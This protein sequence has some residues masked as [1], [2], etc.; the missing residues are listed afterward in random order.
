PQA[1]GACRIGRWLYDPA[2]HTLADGDSVLALTGGESN[3]LRAL[4]SRA[5]QVVAR[6]ELAVLC[7]L[8]AGGER[9]IDVQVTR[10][11]RKLE[12]DAKAPRLLQTVRGKGYLLRT[13]ES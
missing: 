2:G 7:G 1:L 3:L 6:D 4:A 11:R 8:E 12:D 13:G 9:T 5:G 10:L